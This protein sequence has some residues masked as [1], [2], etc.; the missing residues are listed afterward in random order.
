MTR[1]HKL[2]LI[3]GFTLV[4]VVGVLISDHFSK[5]HE[6]RLRTEMPETPARN[7]AADG[8]RPVGAGSSGGGGGGGSIFFGPAPAS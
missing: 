5:A 1:E 4:L 2:A 8:L 7:L 3:I 6:A